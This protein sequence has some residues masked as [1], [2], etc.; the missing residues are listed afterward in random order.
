MVYAMLDKATALPALLRRLSGL[1][2]G[3]ALDLRTYKRNRSVLIR[4]TDADRFRVT[5]EGFRREVFQ[6]PFS[7]LKKLLKVLFKREFPRST[8]IRVYDLGAADGQDLPT[9]RKV[10]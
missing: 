8:K 2:M 6:V 1:P 4:R 5:E 10:I 3:H 9:G 7:D